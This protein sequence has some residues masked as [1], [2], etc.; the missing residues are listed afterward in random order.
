MIKLK[1]KCINYSNL[2]V[3]IFLINDIKN[4]IIVQKIKLKFV[5]AIDHLNVIYKSIVIH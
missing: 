5:T 3:I 1:R 4:K 2:K